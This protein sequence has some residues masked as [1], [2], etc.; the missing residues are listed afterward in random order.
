MSLSVTGDGEMSYM[1]KARMLLLEQAS[2]SPGIANGNDTNGHDTNLEFCANAAEHQL[3][4]DIARLTEETPLL[5]YSP[6]FQAAVLDEAQAIRQSNAAALSTASVAGDDAISNDDDNDNT[7]DAI[8]PAYTPDLRNNPLDELRLLQEHDPCLHIPQATGTGFQALSTQKCAVGKDSNP[9]CNVS[10]DRVAL[11]I[12]YYKHAEGLLGTERAEKGFIEQICKLQEDPKA[13]VQSRICCKHRDCKIVCFAGKSS[14]NL[15]KS[16][17]QDSDERSAIVVAT[18]ESDNSES[19]GDDDAER[20]Q[21]PK[22]KQKQQAKEKQQAKAISGAAQQHAAVTKAKD[23]DTKFEDTCILLRKLWVE[24]RI[25]ED[26]IS[27]A[28]TDFYEFSYFAESR[29]RAAISV[30]IAVCRNAE[31]ARLDVLKNH[32]RA[33]KFVDAVSNV[34]K[35]FLLKVVKD[36]IVSTF[37]GNAV[38]DKNTVPSSKAEKYLFGAR[39]WKSTLKALMKQ[40]FPT[41]YDSAFLLGRVMH[42]ENNSSP[43]K[44]VEKA[45]ATWYFE[46][47][48]CFF[49]DAASTTTTLVCEVEIPASADTAASVSPAASAASANTAASAASAASAKPATLAPLGPIH[50]HGFFGNAKEVSNLF[51]AI[52]TAVRNTP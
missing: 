5:E 48:A 18:Q 40:K 38:L 31:L 44:Q 23:A 43:T 13:S 34:P 8:K 39:S 42:W 22:K 17:T 19:D 52:V 12:D 1:P 41:P 21:R 47:N 32:E 9:N 37:W 11:L 50:L 46:K 3:L 20:A 29:H 45:D 28:L 10:G 25:T 33:Q 16:K 36:H 35:Q 7:S 27:T 49:P 6:D 24:D 4:S 30:A 14:A 15:T 26:Q 51:R 2:A